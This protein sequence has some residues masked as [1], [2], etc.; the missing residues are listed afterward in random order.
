VNALIRTVVL[1]LM[2]VVL[3]HC[4]PVQ[5]CS[6]VAWKSSG[7]CGEVGLPPDWY[8]DSALKTY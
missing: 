5:G 6:D 7:P 1:V 4:G 8:G 2:T 3:Q